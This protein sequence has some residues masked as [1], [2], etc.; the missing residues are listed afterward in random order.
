MEDGVMQIAQEQTEKTEALIHSPPF[1]PVSPCSRWPILTP[2][3]CAV[4]LKRIA[5][6]HEFR[7]E[8][9][10]LFPLA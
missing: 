3:R 2:D 1:P 5:W 10:R 6:R 7:R 4:I 9:Q 8:I